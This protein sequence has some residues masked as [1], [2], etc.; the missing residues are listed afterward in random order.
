MWA[1]MDRFG[2]FVLIMGTS[3]VLGAVALLT[4]D[5]APVVFWGLLTL[6]VVLA[7]VGAFLLWLIRKES[8]MRLGIVERV[9]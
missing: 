3:Y 4:V 2:R 5:L 6:C 8:F 7:F 1:Q 9:R